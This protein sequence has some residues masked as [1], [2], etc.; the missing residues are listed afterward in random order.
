[1]EIIEVYARRIFDSRGNPTVEVE[2]I[3]EGGI[4]GRAA[5]PSG[6]STGEREALELRDG[7]KNF[8]GKDVEKAIKNVNEIIGP[9]IEGENVFDQRFI[10]K[11]MIEL[12]GT[13]NKSH[14]GANAILG[15]S[16]AVARAAANF[17]D[18]PLYFY[19]GGVSANVLPVPMCNIINGGLHADNNLDIQEFMIAPIGAK[20]FSE[21]YKMAVEVFLHLKKILKEK[22]YSISVGDEGGFAPNL[23]K[24]E[25]A[26]QLII[27]AIEK[28]GYIPGKDVA[29]AIDTAA[30]SLYENNTYNFEGKKVISDDLIEFYE[31]IVEKYPVYS[32]ED[33]LAENDW[34]GWKKLT[35]V[36]GNKIQ[37]V[38]DD[39][40]VTNPKIFKEGIKNKIGNAILIKLNQIGTLTETLETIEMAKRNGY[41]AIISHRSGET[42]DTFIADLTVGTNA[43][44]IKSG[45]LS[46]SE[47]LCKYNQLLRIEENLGGMGKYYGEIL[48][49]Y[50]KIKK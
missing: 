14:L 22:G 19:L 33:G 36:L 23:N 29:I 21:G 3:V 32:L 8:L 28:A 40:F 37:L 49:E 48:K 39:I 18:V 20:S 12:D 7:G 41:K 15:V 10:D 27:S 38:G 2:V 25:E 9:E 6:A 34:D 47:R 11:K 1:M 24:N 42:E 16:M 44:Q 35:E 31:K 13:E 5:V 26:I 17:L 45:S 46:R 43:G 4:T 50:E 30:S